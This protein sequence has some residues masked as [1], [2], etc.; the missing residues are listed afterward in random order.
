[1]SG[2]RCISIPLPCSLKSTFLSLLLGYCACKAVKHQARS[3]LW[4]T[5]GRGAKQGSL[6][7]SCFFMHPLRYLP[8]L[9]DRFL[10]SI[11]AASLFFS[12]SMPI[13]ADRA[14]RACRAVVAEPNELG[15]LLALLDRLDYVLEKCRLREDDSDAAIVS[16]LRIKLA[17]EHQFC[18]RMSR[19]R[20]HAW[21]HAWW[22]IYSHYRRPPSLLL[23]SEA[24]RGNCQRP[25]I[26]WIPSAETG[27]SGG[28]GGGG[29]AAGENTG[30][31][32][33]PTGGIAGQGCG[34]GPLHLSVL[35]DIFRHKR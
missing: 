9:S 6:S 23:M 34:H 24:C 30:S 5:L 32:F 3:R 19:G 7:R 14:E 12:R 1:M 2:V 10:D 8:D 20:L 21:C 15:Q 16:F 11:K 4:E 33:S 18:R 13:S 26:F 28:G 17:G 25:H 35:V 27:G 22:I 29:G 31:I